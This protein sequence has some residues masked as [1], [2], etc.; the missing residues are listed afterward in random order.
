MDDATLLARFIDF[1]P[2]AEGG[3]ALK[4][5]IDEAMMARLLRAMT[6]L[7]ERAK[8]L[9]ELMKGAQFLLLARPLAMDDKAKQIPARG[10]RRWRH[11]FRCWTARPTGRPPA[12]EQA[13]KAHAKIERVKARQ[14]RTAAPRSTHRHQHLPRHFSMYWRSWGGTRRWED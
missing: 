9:V 1:L 8:T 11:S 6:G 4:S 2:H 3:A 14:T 10:R 12:L 7:K 13:V 5:R